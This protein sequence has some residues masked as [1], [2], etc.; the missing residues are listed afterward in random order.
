MR[1]PSKYFNNG[2]QIWCHECVSE[3]FHM[4]AR[5]KSDK[6]NWY[7]L[8]CENGHFQT[9]Y[10]PNTL[11]TTA[12]PGYG[13]G[14]KIKIVRHEITVVYTK[15]ITLYL[16]EDEEVD[17]HLYN[18]ASEFDYEDSEEVCHDEHKTEDEYDPAELYD[19]KCHLR[20]E[21]DPINGALKGCREEE[22]PIAA[23]VRPDM[24]LDAFALS[25]T[26]P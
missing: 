17:D 13:D 9:V 24:T 12:I 1:E 8:E 16:P 10:T 3:K 7:N 26:P 25:P 11:R 14:Q 20:K 15:Y 23:S 5:G 19:D 6:S 2:N 4:L 21:W 18:Y 22:E